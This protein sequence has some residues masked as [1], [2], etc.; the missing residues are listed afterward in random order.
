MA[1]RPRDMG[2]PAILFAALLLSVSCAQ[3]TASDAA[4]DT[5]EPVPTANSVLDGEGEYAAEAER[6]LRIIMLQHM[7]AFDLQEVLRM[8]FDYPVRTHVDQRRNALIVSAMSTQMEEVLDIA[9]LLDTPA[10]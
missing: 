8:H 6:E 5:S 10:E 2:S 4:A 1:G 3:V 7:S 9:A